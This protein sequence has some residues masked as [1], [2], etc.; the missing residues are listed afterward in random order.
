MNNVFSTI[1]QQALIVAADAL[2]SDD[3][4]TLKEMGLVGLT[5]SLATKLKQLT[6]QE[7]TCTREFKASLA[8]ITIDHRNIELFI[9]FASRKTDE[10]HLITKAIMG[11]IRQSQLE[12]LKGTTRREYDE[13]RKRLGL[14][15][16]T[17]GRI[18][19]LNEEDELLVFREWEKLS[20]I[21][22]PLV[23]YV[24]LYE[25][26]NISIDRAWVSL[27]QLSGS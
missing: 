27:K 25:K 2:R 9:D 20:S 24:E 15:V 3:I 1:N 13:R 11:G 7:I 6:L 19:Q 18:E 21:Q 23:R 14:Q 22:D 5:E 8:S 16:H 4:T 10:D 12:V 17:K 26:T